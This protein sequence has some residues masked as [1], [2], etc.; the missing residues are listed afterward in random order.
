MVGTNG[1][2]LTPSFG[3]LKAVFSLTWP[4]PS[5]CRHLPG[6]GSSRGSLSPAAEACRRMDGAKN[7]FPHPSKESWRPASAPRAAPVPQY[8]RGSGL[9]LNKA[10]R[11]RY[12]KDLWW[13]EDAP[14]WSAPFY[15][16]CARE[17]LPVDPS[18]GHAAASQSGVL[19]FPVSLG[20]TMERTFREEG[21]IHSR[22][23]PTHGAEL[24][25]FGQVIIFFPIKTRN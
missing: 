24:P 23:A 9:G 1:G 18:V 17:F 16:E 20:L 13:G 14:F 15:C 5:L 22:C 19:C 21:R 11:P 2:A 7:T 12:I 3:G 25:E 10:N 8:C 4:C 6:T